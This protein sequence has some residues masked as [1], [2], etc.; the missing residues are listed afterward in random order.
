MPSLRRAFSSPSVRVSPYPALP[1]SR[2][3]RAHPHGHRRSSGSDVSDRKVLADIDWWRVAAGQRE[4]GCEEEDEEEGE[5]EERV[6]VGEENPAPV[7]SADSETMAIASRNDAIPGLPITDRG[8]SATGVEPE[9]SS[10]PVA[11]QSPLSEG[12][13]HNVFGFSFQPHVFGQLA[14]E[15]SFALR[16]RT[17]T[18]RRNASESSTSSVDSTPDSEVLRTPIERPSFACMGFADPGPESPLFHVGLAS[19]HTIPLV[20][21]YDSFGQQPGGVDL[22]DDKIL[23]D[24]LMCHDDLFA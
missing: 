7:D 13:D 14:S 18:R 12:D 3:H 2:S 6:V 5:G 1:S 10:T 15:S 8:E 17:P 23:P 20:P 9:R 19:L 24:P 16:P 11:S 21:K 22:N 4:R